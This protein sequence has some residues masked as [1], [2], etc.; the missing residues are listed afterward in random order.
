MKADQGLHAGGLEY[1]R[2]Q[3]SLLLWQVSLG[4]VFVFWEKKK[5]KSKSSWVDVCFLGTCWLGVKGS[6]GCCYCI[7]WMQ[8][9]P[10]LSVLSKPKLLWVSLPGSGT[11]GPSARLG[12]PRGHLVLQ[13]GWNAV[14]LG[15]NRGS[16][17]PGRA[18]G[19]LQLPGGS[20][21]PEL[22]PAG[23]VAGPDSPGRAQAHPGQPQCQCG[24]ALSSLMLH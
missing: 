7:S 22:C 2:K 3:P 5:K 4:F 19:S 23:P 14:Q 16:P 11:G 8:L 1:G 12:T 17:S 13:R 21:S 15:G 24:D 10:A 6:V 9:Q 20:E 18:G